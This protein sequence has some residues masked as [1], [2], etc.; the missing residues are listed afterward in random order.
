MVKT[1]V[2]CLTNKTSTTT[3]AIIGNMTVE[4][5]ALML[6]EGGH[7]NSLGRTSDVVA[8]VL[9]N[10]ERLDELYNCMF[11]EDAW[12]RMRAADAFEKICREHSDWI[13]PYIDKIQ[14]QLSGADQQASIK[15]HIVQ[16]YR[17]VA[18]TELQKRYALEWLS[19]QI[20]TIDVDWIVAANAMETLAYFVKKR[21]FNTRE[22]E[23]LLHIQQNHKS[24]S[25]VKK[26]NKIMNEISG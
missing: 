2:K 1:I 22:L 4:T 13:E 17:Q 8:V 20:S 25:V 26:A 21:D 14:N 23:R 11:H 24:N 6:R 7:A 19:E 16:L 12:V 15:W 3:F 5:F 18:L 10:R 9:H